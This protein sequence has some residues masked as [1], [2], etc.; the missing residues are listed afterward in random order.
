MEEV[1]SCNPI[2][3]LSNSIQCLAIEYWKKENVIG[4]SVWVIG[5]LLLTWFKYNPN[6]DKYPHAQ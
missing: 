4:E 2:D 3:D 1:L 5:P 6:M